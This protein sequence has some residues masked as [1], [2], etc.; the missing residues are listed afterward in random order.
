MVDLRV[1]VAALTVSYDGDMY[2]LGRPDLGSYVGVP[3]PGAVLITSLQAGCPL[4][5]AITRA[6]KVAGEPVDG[7][8]FL[9]GLSEAGLLDDPAEAGGGSTGRRGRQIRWIEGLSPSTVTWLFGRS[10]W[11]LYSVSALAAATILLTRPELRPTW[12]DSWFLP[13]PAMSI[14]AVAAISM[15][16]SVVHEIW[17]WMAGRAIG[18]PAVF[19]V[20]YRGVYLVFET[21]LTQLVAMP[22]RR[23][24]GPFLAG[25][26]WDVTML[27]AALNARLLAEFGLNLPPLLDRLLGVVVLIQVLGITWQ[28]VGIFLRSDGYA[29]L[30]NLFGCHDLYR[31]SWLTVKDRLLRLTDTERTE[32]EAA[33][34]HDRSVAGW[35]SVLYVAGMLVMVWIFAHIAVPSAIAIT[36]WATANVASLAIGTRDFWESAAVL[37]YLLTQYGLPPVL[38]VRERRLRRSGVLR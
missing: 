25:M 24:Y 4:A 36:G 10:A 17:H 32:F 5:E 14:L 7:D 2:V 21:D 37:A 38:A 19:R 28:W 30:A 23:R 20:S 11:A 27:A 6:S 26:A 35:F 3:E 33:G 15:V 1:K 8:D 34:D 18:V 29:V 12:E 16:L 9:R 13:D 31:V 22:R